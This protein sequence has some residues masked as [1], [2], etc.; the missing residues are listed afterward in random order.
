ME[1]EMET[2]FRR[3]FRRVICKL[4]NYYDLEVGFGRRIWKQMGFVMVG[5][6][7][8]YTWRLDTCF[9]SN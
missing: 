2:E 5:F 8:Q 1:T 6:Q 3:V 7:K 4:L 9:L